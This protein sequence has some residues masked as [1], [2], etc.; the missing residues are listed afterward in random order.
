MYALWIQICLLLVFSSHFYISDQRSGQSPRIRCKIRFQIYD[1][2]IYE[3]P[4]FFCDMADQQDILHY[5]SSQ[6]CVRHFSIG[7]STRS[8]SVFGNLNLAQ[9]SCQDNY[10]QLPSGVAGVAPWTNHCLV[11]SLFLIHPNRQFKMDNSNM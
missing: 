2:H 7:F 11:P 5:M 6:L 10:L 1:Q 8:K 3:T 9:E 4:D